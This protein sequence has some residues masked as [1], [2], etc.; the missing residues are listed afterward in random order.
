MTEQ[1]PA[2]KPGIWS[3]LA[4]A[5]VVVVSL[6]V[7][8]RPGLMQTPPFRVVT[9]AAS[10]NGGG[11]PVTPWPLPV[12]VAIAWIIVGAVVSRLGDGTARLKHLLLFAFGLRLI[13][14]L[15]HFGSYWEAQFQQYLD[16]LNHF[17]AFVYADMAMQLSAQG[18]SGDGPWSGINYQGIVYYYG[19]LFYLFGPNP[20][21]GVV[22]NCVLAAITPVVLYRFMLLVTR[23]RIAEGAA[24]GIA[25]LPESWL[26]SSLLM[27]ESLITL[28]FV[29]GVLAATIASRTRS[30]WAVV[31]ALVCAG[32]LL[33]LR[34]AAAMIMMLSVAVATLIWHRRHIM[35]LA[36]YGALFV[37]LVGIVT[38]FSNNTLISAYGSPLSPAFYRTY[39][40]VFRERQAMD[41]GASEA[42][43]LGA[44]TSGALTEGKVYWIPV[45]AGMFYLNPPPW[46]TGLGSWDPFKM[47]SAAVVWI[48]I[49]AA[50]IG[51][52]Q[53]WKKPVPSSPLWVSWLF[54]TVLISSST[55]F[56]DDRLRMMMMPLYLG[57]SATGFSSLRQWWPIYA[58]FPPV[59]VVAGILFYLYKSGA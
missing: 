6:I 52:L 33:Q 55:P 22:F 49:P 42:S 43:S 46:T 51:L 47:T 34:I 58:V 11:F 26:W 17:D 32:L 56:I 24:L 28:V 7:A 14:G 29:A 30:L 2:K 25:L 13:V 36:A 15:L 4:V 31:A 3:K 5:V 40:E 59:A 16:G 53:L 44:R 19:V 35:R 54:G 37:M 9:A 39:A 21:V 10:Q 57:V 50:L 18:L 23:E 48:C 20:A 27:K 41:L 8:T 45:R 1:T 12:V 38:L